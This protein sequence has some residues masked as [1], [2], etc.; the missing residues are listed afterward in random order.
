MI[1][2]ICRGVTQIAYQYI[3]FLKNGYWEDPVET[4]QDSTKQWEPLWRMLKSMIIH[5]IRFLP[6]LLTGHILLSS[7]I[8]SGTLTF[9][10]LATALSQLLFSWR[11]DSTETDHI[12]RA[13]KVL[14]V[15]LLNYK[16][17][18]HGFHLP[19]PPHV[20]WHVSWHV[21]NFRF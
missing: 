8:R 14:H 2:Q 4:T 17:S 20:S 12:S 15:L 19:V 21:R 7:T 10:G 18:H 16:P 5:L 1:I 6:F 3:S 13:K 9:I 11:S